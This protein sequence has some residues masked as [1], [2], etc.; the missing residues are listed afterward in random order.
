MTLIGVF[1]GTLRRVFPRISL[2]AISAIMLLIAFWAFSRDGSSQEGSSRHNSRMSR[3]DTFGAG[4]TAE[5]LANLEIGMRPGRCVSYRFRDVY[6]RQGAHI[7][8]NVIINIANQKTLMA[9]SAEL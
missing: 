7:L 6:K 9:K 4:W 3:P 5:S 8:K 2:R 1:S